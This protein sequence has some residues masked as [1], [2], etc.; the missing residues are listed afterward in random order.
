M[1]RPMMHSVL[2]LLI[3]GAFV[4]GCGSEDTT[5]DPQYQPAQQSSDESEE[6]AKLPPAESTPYVVPKLP[7]QGLTIVTA[8]PIDGPEEVAWRFFKLKGEQKYEEALEL[9]G[10][11]LYG[12]YKDEPEQIFL[13]EVIHSEFVRAADVTSL[14][15]REGETRDAFDYRVIYVEVNFKL[16]GK[17]TPEQTDMRNGLNHYAVHL[18]QKEQ[19]SPWEIVLLGG[20]PWLEE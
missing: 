11:Y 18:I 10:G 19:G 16:R 1:P 12:S 7:K 5:S 4:V 6:P 9:L 13:R 2:L 15:P 17:L 8:P 14:A 20:S 3:A